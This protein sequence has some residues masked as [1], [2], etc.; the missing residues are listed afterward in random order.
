MWH[1]KNSK[2][3]SIAPQV[4]SKNSCILALILC[5]LKRTFHCYH[6]VLR[7]HNQLAGNSIA[8]VVLSIESRS[9]ISISETLKEENH[10]QEKNLHFN[11]WTCLYSWQWEHTLFSCTQRLKIGREIVSKMSLDKHLQKPS[12]SSKPKIWTRKLH[13]HHRLSTC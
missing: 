2:R 5:P 8:D 3:M 13:I 10:K 7:H 9:L 1:I 6:K 11:Q 4:D 12:S